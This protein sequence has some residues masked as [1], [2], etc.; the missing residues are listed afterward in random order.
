MEEEREDVYRLHTKSIIKNTS[1]G[2]LDMVR[3]SFWMEERARES[4][5]M[6]G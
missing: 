6:R 5:E 2:D 4:R 1:W 3:G